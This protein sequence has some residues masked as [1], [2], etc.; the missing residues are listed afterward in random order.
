MPIFLLLNR[1]ERQHVLDVRQ[2]EAQAG[3]VL[4]VASLDW[5]ADIGGAGPT[6]LI[7]NGARSR[8]AAHAE[9]ASA[10]PVGADVT[11][12]RPKAVDNN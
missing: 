5:R 2:D 8:G 10:S 4:S 6:G 12:A 1:A 3:P 11:P 7:S 9:T